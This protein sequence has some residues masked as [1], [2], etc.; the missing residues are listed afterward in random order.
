MHSR[1]SDTSCGVAIAEAEHPD[2]GHALTDST[3]IDAMEGPE[4]QRQC[5]E[6]TRESYSEESAAFEI[7]HG[8]A[9]YRVIEASRCR[10]LKLARNACA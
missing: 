4:Q 10:S 5:H 8:S 3:K 9:A 1:H 6:P 7:H 2:A